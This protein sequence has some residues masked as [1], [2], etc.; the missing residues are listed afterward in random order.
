MA[1][2]MLRLQ[3]GRHPNP[4]TA[5]ALE[6]AIQRLDHLARINKIL[7]QHGQGDVQAGEAG[8][9]SLLPCRI[10]VGETLATAGRGRGERHGQWS[11]PLRWLHCCMRARPYKFGSSGLARG[12]RRGWD[13]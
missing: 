5:A 6:E 11:A 8:W 7:Y 13:P 4:D 1:I 3:I 12:S 2:A 10:G 9:F